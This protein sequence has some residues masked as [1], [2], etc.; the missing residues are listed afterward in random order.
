MSVYEHLFSYV[1]K[2]LVML[3]L[4]THSKVWRARNNLAAGACEMSKD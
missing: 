4:W 1:I 3:E 2:E